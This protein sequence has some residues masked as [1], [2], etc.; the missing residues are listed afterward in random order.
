ME[1]ERNGI[2]WPKTTELFLWEERSLLLGRWKALTIGR[3]NSVNLS[4]FVFN[5]DTPIVLYWMLLEPF[6]T[7]TALYVSVECHQKIKFVFQILWRPHKPMCFAYKERVFNGHRITKDSVFESNTLIAFNPIPVYRAVN[8]S[9]ENTFRIGVIDTKNSSIL[10]FYSFQRDMALE[11]KD[12]SD[13]DCVLPLFL[14]DIPDYW[15]SN[16]NAILDLTNDTI[17]QRQSWLLL[18]NNKSKPLFCIVDKTQNF[19]KG[20]RLDTSLKFI[21]TSIDL[22]FSALRRK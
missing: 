21:K 8:L 12:C 9:H 16:L 14:T 6:M 7:S 4:Q 3:R 2:S 5:L 17:N 18:F 11:P 19:T 15:R 10:M 1:R 20:V 22:L 13:V